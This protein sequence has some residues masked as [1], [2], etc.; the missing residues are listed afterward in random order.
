MSSLTV[1]GIYENGTVTLLETPEGVG[2]A[3][4]AVTF[5]A[6]T[7]TPGETKRQAVQR[8]IGF[9]RQGIDFGDGGFDRN[10]IHEE[11]LNRLEQRRG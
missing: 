7:E 1:E 5:L 10:A 2:R 9:M 3:R 8:M 4:V 6:E 11:R